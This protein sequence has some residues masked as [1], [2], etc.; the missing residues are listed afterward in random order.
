M[1]DPERYSGEALVAALNRKQI[2]VTGR[3][4]VVRT[5]PVLPGTRLLFTFQSPPMREIIAGILRPSQNWMAEQLLKTLGY[6]RGAGGKWREGR[7]VER[8][9]L[10]DVVKIDSTAF[11]I[12]DGSGLSAQNVMS[13]RGFVQL[14]EHARKS[15]WGS[16]Y[17]DAL[18]IPG[19]VQPGANVGAG[20]LTNRLAGLETRLAAKTGTIANVNALSGYL[21]TIDGRDVTF[22]IVT[23]ASG[24]PSSEMRRAIDAIVQAIARERAWD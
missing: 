14:L 5:P 24:R 13:P 1:P 17:R 15:P 11:S 16:F 21:R 3:L 22:S 4:S 8:R 2:G 23:N 18:P 10:I 19:V 9:Y 6:T 12:S 20:T 7:S